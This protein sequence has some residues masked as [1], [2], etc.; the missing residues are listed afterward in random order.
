MN[1]S[2]QSTTHLFKVLV[3]VFAVL[4]VVAELPLPSLRLS[5]TKRIDEATDIL[6]SQILLTRQ[7]ALA[8]RMRYRIQYDY[9]TGT[10]ATYRE[11]SPGRWLPEDGNEARM[12]RRV[13]IS[14]TSTPSN[15]H[16]EIDANGTIENH[17]VPVVI[18]LGDD[19]GTQK[20]IRLSPAGM[21]QE[22]P[23]W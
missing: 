21:A 3:F 8:G 18:R 6:C 5:R 20:S 10:C 4:V 15:G 9:V 12:P 14:P 13:A 22:I 17:G 11:V 19:E 2:P 1:R 16:I 23:T 7:K